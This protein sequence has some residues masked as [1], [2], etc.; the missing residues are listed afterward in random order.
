MAV[1]EWDRRQ[2]CSDGGCTG[3]INATGV[4]GTCGRAAPNW[5]DERKRGLRN[6]TDAPPIVKDDDD[7]APSAPAA[8]GAMADWTTRRL[9]TDGGCVGVLGPNNKCKVCGKPGPARKAKAG[10][11]TAAVAAGSDTELERVAAELAGTATAGDLASIVPDATKGDEDDEYEDDEDDDEYE[12]DEDDEDDDDEHEDDDAEETSDEDHDHGDENDRAEAD[13]ES[14]D[15]SGDAS[16]DEDDDEGEDDDDED[17]EDDSDED[18][19]DEDDAEGDEDGAISASGARE[20]CPDGACVG[21][22]GANG[23]CKICD[24]PRDWRDEPA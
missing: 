13:D 6:P 23:R 15:R 1:E 22:L 12:D 11:A 16:D 14:D 3:L 18:D 8:L 9:C 4:C 5:G 19:S 2:L 24:K 10:A 17:D 20:L 7:I 21:V